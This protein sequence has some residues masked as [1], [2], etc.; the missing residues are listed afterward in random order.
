MK[1]AHPRALAAAAASLLLTGCLNSTTTV[2]V[3]KDGSGAIEERSL[4][5]ADFVELMNQFSQGLGSLLGNDTKSTKS[6]NPILLDNAT[7]VKR[8]ASLGEGV[9]FVSAEEVKDPSGGVGALVRYHFT[10]VRKLQLRIEDTMSAL[11]TLKSAIPIQITGQPDFQKSFGGAPITFSFDPGE[12]ATLGIHLPVPDEEALVVATAQAAKAKAPDPD[13]LARAREFLG[14][15][16]FGL[17]VKVDGEV[18]SSNATHQQDTAATLFAM[19][20]DR[21]LK[22]PESFAKIQALG[23]QKDV[24]KAKKELQEIDGMTL[25][26]EESIEIRFK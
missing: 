19:D 26:T 4:A 18:V 12:V 5:G 17:I 2:T 10:D 24:A 13:D 9:T 25:E 8:T 11:D 1:F 16:R 6:S 23:D 14:D 21:I 22:D 3:A 7:Y 20:F 15:M